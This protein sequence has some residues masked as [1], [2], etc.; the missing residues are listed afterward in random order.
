[1]EDLARISLRRAP[2]Y[3]GV[4]DAAERATVSGLEQGYMVCPAQQRFLLLFTFLKKNRGKKVIVFMSSCNRCARASRAGP[5][6]AA[7]RAALIAPRRPGSVK[8]HAELL[9]YIDIP[10]LDLHG[11]QKQQKRTST[12][13]EFCNAD[14]GALICTDVAARGWTFP[15]STGSCSTTAGTR[16]TF[17][18]R[19]RACGGSSAA[20]LTACRW[21]TEWD[22]RREASTAPRA[23]P[24]APE[25]GIPAA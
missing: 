14:K 6:A 1:M 21:W 5:G 11:R 16:G 23:A 3:I 8:F 20:W 18:V 13:F 10:V 12:F 17:T 25:A 9:N 19:A 15:P 22:A 24:A 4:H 7:V 2:M